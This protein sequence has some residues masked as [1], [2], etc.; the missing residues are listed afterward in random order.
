MTYGT[1]RCRC[2]LSWGSADPGQHAG[3]HPEPPHT[4]LTA[5]P[6]LLSPQVGWH[7]PPGPRTRARFSWRCRRA[8]EP[9]PG[10]PGSGPCPAAPAPGAHRGTAPRAEPKPARPA[11]QTCRASVAPPGAKSHRQWPDQMLPWGYKVPAAPRHRDATTVSNLP[12][13]PLAS[14]RL[15]DESIPCLRLQDLQ[16]AAA[17][18]V[19]ESEEQ[20]PPCARTSVRHRPGPKR[21]QGTR[22]DAHLTPHTSRGALRPRQGRRSGCRGVTSWLGSGDPIRGADHLLRRQKPEA[23]VQGA[24]VPGVR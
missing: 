6:E 15:Q 11:Q 7:L 14:A 12:V 3:W 23:L 9:P 10:G 5:S 17:R 13:A 4:A 8:Q 24:L 22:W 2:A 18:T 16:V 1:G 19:G 21:Q 20:R